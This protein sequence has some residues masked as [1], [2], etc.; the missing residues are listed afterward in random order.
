MFSNEEDWG[1]PQING[2]DVKQDS[3]DIIFYSATQEGLEP[4]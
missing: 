1:L 2:Q 3:P 4:L